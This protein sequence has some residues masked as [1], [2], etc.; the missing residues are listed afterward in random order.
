MF[1]WT[2]CIFEE[3]SWNDRIIDKRK[4]NEEVWDELKSMKEVFYCADTHI[5]KSWEGVSLN[6]E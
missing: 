5:R 3:E 4:E 2:G 1:D 6:K